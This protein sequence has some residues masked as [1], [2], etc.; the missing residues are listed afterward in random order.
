MKNYFFM[1]CL[2]L[3]FLQ[4]IL[5]VA[6]NPVNESCVEDPFPSELLDTL[7]LYQRITDPEAKEAYIIFKGRDGNAIN[8]YTYRASG[9]SETSGQIVFVLHGAARNADVYISK[10][11]HIAERH[12]ALL[13]APEFKES[14]YGPG[15]DRYTLGVGKRKPPYSGKYESSMWLERDSYLY[16]EIE[17]LF[18]AIRQKLGNRNCTYRIW[19]HSAGGQF[20]HRL[21]TFR[22][23]ARVA[24][25]VSANAGFYTLPSYGRKDEEKNFFLSL[26]GGKPNW[27]YHMPYGL[28][29]TPLESREVDQLLEAPLTIVIGDRDIKSGKGS[30]VRDSKQANFQGINRYERALFYYETGKEEAG[31]RGLDFG[32]RLGVV[33][34]VG[35]N[36]RRI[37]PSVAWYL[38][39]KPGAIPCTPSTVKDAGGLVINELLADP[40]GDTRGDANNDG[41]RDPQADE[42]VE[43]V[44]TSRNNICLSGWT[45]GDVSSSS[46]HKFPVGT[47]LEAGKAIVVFGGGVPTGSFGGSVTQTAFFEGELALSN[48]GDVLT[49]ADSRGTVLCQVSWGDCAG[50]ACS[51]DYVSDN[52]AI[53]QSF[54]RWPEASGSFTPH[55]TTE[56]AL[57]FSPGSRADGKNFAGSR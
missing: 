42:F 20:T 33:P 14:L 52:I 22:S 41:Y 46:R 19:G 24:S 7:G 56:S 9:F 17:H 43:L 31:R 2:L 16:S 1:L 29:G 47:L 23:D 38:F 55:T 39:S 4:T 3:F 18:E 50:Q 30:R 8:A 37:A 15:S 26:F 45:L 10:F 27:N 28:Q 13:I 54:T 40:A 25:A 36:T 6:A 51:G 12:D 48:K 35:H 5:A 11:K 32:W 57:R 34:E 21:L 49:L 53:N 44:N